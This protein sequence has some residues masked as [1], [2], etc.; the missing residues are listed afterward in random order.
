MDKQEIF[1]KVATHLLTQKARAEV[2]RSDG[3]RCC[4]YRSKE[5]RNGPVLKC[6]IGCLI[7]DS[8]YSQELEGKRVEHQEVVRALTNSGIDA[9]HDL[10]ALTM[11]NSLQAIHDNYEVT[12]WYYRLQG[13]ADRFNLQM[14]EIPN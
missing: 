7:A 2:L 9:F 13:I 3:I 8:A 12:N 4:A 1:T 5:S 10:S 14:P 11:L 6:A